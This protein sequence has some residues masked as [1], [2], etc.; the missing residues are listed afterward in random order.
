MPIDRYVITDRQ[1]S[2]IEQHC[3]DRKS[4]PGRTGSDGR[5]FLEGVF[6]IARTGAQ[7]HDLPGGFGKWNTVCRRFR[8][9]ARLGVFE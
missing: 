8:D 7:W 3:L 4:D 1:W 5:L 6:W 2:K 9:W